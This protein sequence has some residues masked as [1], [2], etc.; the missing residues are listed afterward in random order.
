LNIDRYLVGAREAS[1]SW[2]GLA[3]VEVARGIGGHPD[4]VIDWDEGAGESWVRLIVGGVVVA[5]VSTDLPLVIIDRDMAGIDQLDPKVESI[6]V[7]SMENAEL[8][9][10]KAALEAAFGHSRRLD[11]LN[12]EWFSADDLWYATV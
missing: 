4:A 6:L 8:S 11:L 10:S 7:E 9:G 2:T 12:K 5:Y 1:G 3:A